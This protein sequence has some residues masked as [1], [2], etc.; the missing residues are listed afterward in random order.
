M[1][2]EKL[3]FDNQAFRTLKANTTT[4]LIYLKNNELWKHRKRFKRH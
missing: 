2:A 1:F 3:V 4:N